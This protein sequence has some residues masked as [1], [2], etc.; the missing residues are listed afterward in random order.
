MSGMEVG[1]CDCGWDGE[2]V[3]PRAIT[4]PMARVAHVCDECGEAINPGERYHHLRGMCEGEWFTHK[5]CEIC[6]RI[7]R[8]FCAPLGDLRYT[9]QNLLGVDYVT[10]ETCETQDERW[11]RYSRERAARAG[12]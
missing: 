7:G 2:P 4:T 6:H 12:V 8:D 3:Y 11:D 9:V 5:T 10:G 1:A